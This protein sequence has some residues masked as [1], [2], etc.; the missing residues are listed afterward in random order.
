MDYLIKAV[1][2]HRDFQLRSRSNCPNNNKKFTL[3]LI[4]WII[5]LKLLMIT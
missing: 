4:K 3:N 5:L 2:D 1:N